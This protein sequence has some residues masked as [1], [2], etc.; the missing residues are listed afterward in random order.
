MNISKIL[1]NIIKQIC[2]ILLYFFLAVFLQVVFYKFLTASN[3][4]L[5]NLS[6]ILIELLIMTIFIVIFRHQIVPD[7]ADFKKNGKKYLKKYYPYWLVGLLI[8]II[9]N[10]IISKFIG[11][12]A[13]ETANRQLLKMYPAYI[14]ITSI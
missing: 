8:M 1:N 10:L 14:I 7:F 4:V 6:Y 5:A 3:L 12:P 11:M 9:S 13:N 2:L